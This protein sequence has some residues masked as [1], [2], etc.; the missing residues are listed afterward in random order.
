M[1]QPGGVGTNGV[2]LAEIKH[3]RAYC[4]YQ[5]VEAERFDNDNAPVGQETPNAIIEYMS[6]LVD[7]K[8]LGFSSVERLRNALVYFYKVVGNLDSSWNPIINEQN[9]ADAN[10]VKKHLKELK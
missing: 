10:Q 8:G 5:R 6:L 2:E 9:P 4:L 7:H 3:F 1:L